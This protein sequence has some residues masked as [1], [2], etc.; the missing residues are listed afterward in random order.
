[1]TIQKAWTRDGQYQDT[2]VALEESARESGA[3]CL[4]GLLSGSSASDGEGDLRHDLLS[5]DRDCG[6]FTNQAEAQAFYEAAGGPDR[7]PHRL[8]GDND[9]IACE[10][11]PQALS[12]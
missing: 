12:P 4:W 10:A 5:L 11:L 7:D 6:D 9:N 8:D 1:M 3:G 2:L